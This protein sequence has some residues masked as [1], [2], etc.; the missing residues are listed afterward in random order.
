MPRKQN[1]FGNPKSFAFKGGGRVDVGK[2]KGA[3]GF[4]PSSV[5][6]LS[7]GTCRGN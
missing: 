5:P 3:A 1:G 6:R 4:Y 7:F 2:V